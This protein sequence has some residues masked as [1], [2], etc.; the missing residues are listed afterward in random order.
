MMSD[1]GSDVYVIAGNAHCHT[2]CGVLQTNN[3]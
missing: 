1:M 3:P 2:K